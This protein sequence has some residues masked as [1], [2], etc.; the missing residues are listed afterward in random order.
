MNGGGRGRGQGHTPVRRNH[1]PPVTL[2]QSGVYLIDELR[3]HTTPEGCGMYKIR[4]DNSNCSNDHSGSRDRIV[5]VVRSIQTC[6][7][8]RPRHPLSLGGHFES[9]HCYGLCM[10]PGSGQCHRGTCPLSSPST[11]TGQID[12]ASTLLLSR[13]CIG[14]HE[15]SLL[16][17]RNVG[18]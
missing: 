2:S 12:L 10:S 13:T 7:A 9:G 16:A 6:Q 4:D 11:S 8:H 18:I 5:W 14:S 3:V 17:Y 15:G 1:T